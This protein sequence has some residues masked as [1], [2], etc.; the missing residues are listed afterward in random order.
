M[1]TAKVEAPMVSPVPSSLA[2]EMQSGRGNAVF[3]RE[4]PE[5][6]SLCWPQLL[7]PWVCECGCHKACD[8]VKE[9]RVGAATQDEDV[10]FLEGKA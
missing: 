2:K 3:N 10:K 9:E 1:A 5:A 6:P 4:A 7:L 8:P